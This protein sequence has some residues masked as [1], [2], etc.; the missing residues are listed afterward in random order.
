MR[1]CVLHV[2]IGDSTPT[3]S[4]LFLVDCRSSIKH[5]VTRREEE[6]MTGKCD[7]MKSQTK[8]LY[9]MDTRIALLLRSY[10]LNDTSLTDRENIIAAL[11]LMTGE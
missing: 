11:K 5:R 7:V 8:Q 1:A 2:Q 9:A 10:Y 3:S 6:C 4:S